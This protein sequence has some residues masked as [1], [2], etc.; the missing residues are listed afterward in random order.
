M[1][2]FV[3]VEPLTLLVVVL[4]PYVPLS[5][6]YSNQ[7]VVEMPFALTVPF[8]VAVVVVTSVADS[9]VTVG[10]LPGDE[11]W[12]DISLPYDVPELFCAAIL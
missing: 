2:T 6:P 9:V 12:N 10:A 4:L 3:S 1:F 11:Y 7:A 8:K 5:V